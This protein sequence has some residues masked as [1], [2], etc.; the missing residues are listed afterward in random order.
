MKH[1]GWEL[2]LIICQQ[3]VTSL[4]IGHWQFGLSL[5]PECRML[6]YFLFQFPLFSFV[7]LG[8]FFL[9]KNLYLDA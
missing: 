4:R 3:S 8:G 7:W 6:D 9:L 1:H 2:G 5:N